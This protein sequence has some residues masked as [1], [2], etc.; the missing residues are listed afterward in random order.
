M[1]ALKARLANKV[2]SF[3]EI[4]K[5]IGRPASPDEVYKKL[6]T[7]HLL[8]QSTAPLAPP[9]KMAQGDK[10]LNPVSFSS[11]QSLEEGISA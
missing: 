2:N 10:G 4:V 8:T 3:A 6:G 11:H 7:N 9:K 5:V 1:N